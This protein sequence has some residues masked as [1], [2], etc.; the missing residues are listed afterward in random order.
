MRLKNIDESSLN[1][2]AP[3]LLPILSGIVPTLYHYSNN[4]KNLALA[5]LYQM[6]ALNVIWAIFVYFPLLVLY[7]FE[8]R[9]ASIAAFVFLVYFNVYGLV[10]KYLLDADI[11]RIKHYTFL[12]L[13]LMFAAY[14]MLCVTHLKNSILL[15]IWR[16]LVLMVSALVLINSMSIALAETKRW[17]SGRSVVAAT[18]QEEV[19][20]KQNRPD[21]Y[22]IVLDEFAGFQAMRDYW[23]YEEVDDFVRYLTERGF[24]VAEASHGDSKSTVHEITSRLNYQKYSLDT[25]IQVVF[26]HMANSRVIRYLKAQGY[27]TV[28]F[29]ETKLGIPAAR[30]IEADYLYEYGDPSILQDSTLTNRLY[31]DEF[32]QLI[33]GNTM[34]SVIPISYYSRNAVTDPHHT[35]IRYTVEHVANPAIPSPKFVYVHLLLPHPPFMFTREGD[36]E[37]GH[38]TDWNYYLDNYIYSMKVAQEMISNILLAS[39]STNPPVIILQSDHGAR[40]ESNVESIF[41]PNYPEEYKTLIMNTLYIPGYDYSTLPQDLDPVNTFPIVFNY[42]FDT[43]IPLVK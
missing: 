34:F 16:N 6:L 33:L 28:V 5:N 3:I 36:I 17:W 15:T 13:V 22:Y 18:L 31:L 24:F 4:V 37:F 25:D 2:I 38:F 19:S 14:S 8:A 23:N 26:N 21:I 1:F 9:K 10:Y 11:I 30:P 40:M 27:T 43:D 42:L 29:D 12:P 35:M 41:L 7:R 39:N 20:L 32:G